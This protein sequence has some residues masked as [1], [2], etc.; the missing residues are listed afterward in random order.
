VTDIKYDGRRQRKIQ[1]TNQTWEFWSNACKFQNREMFY[2]VH[3]SVQ[4][5][6]AEKM[7]ARKNDTRSRN[8]RKWYKF[9][10]QDSGTCVT[11]ISFYSV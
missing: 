7:C 8:L 4:E 11:S 6:C 1:P 9:L 3:Y 2:S 5:T 10:V